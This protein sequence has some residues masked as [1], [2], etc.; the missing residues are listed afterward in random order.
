MK[1]KHTVHLA[2]ALNARIVDNAGASVSDFAA[3]VIYFWLWI[4]AWLWAWWLRRP[5]APKMAIAT[6][7]P[8]RSWRCRIST[9]LTGW[10]DDLALVGWAAW[11]LARDWR[12]ADVAI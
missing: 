4:P 3:P 5:P 6:G 7:R 10:R 11:L 8:R 2:V 1:L 12:L 9:Y